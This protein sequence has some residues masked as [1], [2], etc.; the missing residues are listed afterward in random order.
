MTEFS[1]VPKDFELAKITWNHTQKS[2]S[3]DDKHIVNMN[4]VMRFE[5]T[6]NKKTP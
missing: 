5:K 4:V 3:L 1:A 6:K 2:K